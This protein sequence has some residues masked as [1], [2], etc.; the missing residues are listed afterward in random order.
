MTDVRCTVDSCSYWGRGDVCLAESI[1]VKSNMAHDLDD[2][3]P[4]IID[5]EFARDMGIGDEEREDVRPTIRM[6]V[7]T[8]RE[9]CCETM[10]PRSHGEKTKDRRSEHRLSR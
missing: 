1:R 5:T 9:T 2:E 10:R 3:L 7:A 4:A 8:T 6:T